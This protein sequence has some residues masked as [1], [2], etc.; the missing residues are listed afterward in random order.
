[1]EHQSPHTLNERV[2]A[3]ISV[4]V[5][6]VAFR[7]FSDWKLRV[8]HSSPP[9]KVASSIVSTVVTHDPNGQSH[10]HDNVEQGNSPYIQLAT[11]IAGDSRVHTN[12]KDRQLQSKNY[13]GLAK[14]ENCWPASSYHFT[15]LLLVGDLN[16]TKVSWMERL[17]AASNGLFAAA[18][19]K[20]LQQGAWTQHVV[21]PTRCRAGQTLSLLDL[22]ITNERHFVHQHRVKINEMFTSERKVQPLRMNGNRRRLRPG[23]EFVRSC[24]PVQAAR[25]LGRWNDKSILKAQETNRCNGQTFATTV[26]C[27]KSASLLLC[28]ATSKGRKIGRKLSFISN[29]R[30]PLNCLRLVHD[31]KSFRALVLHGGSGQ[32]N[33]VLHTGF[34]HKHVS[35]LPKFCRAQRLII[36]HNKIQLCGTY[37]TEPADSSGKDLHK[38][39]AEFIGHKL[40]LFTRR[41][42]I[43]QQSPADH[44]CAQPEASAECVYQFHGYLVEWQVQLVVLLQSAGIR[45]GQTD[46]LQV[47]KFD[48]EVII[49]IIKDSNISVDT[50]ASL[51]YNHKA[52]LISCC[53]T[54][55]TE[56]NINGRDASARSLNTIPT[57]TYTA[58]VASASPEVCSRKRTRRQASEAALRQTEELSD[59][60][61]TCRKQSRQLGF[62]K[63]RNL[64]ETDDHVKP[65]ID[66]ENLRFT[67][68]SGNSESEAFLRDFIVNQRW[69]RKQERRL[70]TYS[71]VLRNAAIDEKDDEDN[72]V[73]DESP[74]SIFNRLNDDNI[75][76]E[77]DDFLVR[78]RDFEREKQTSGATMLSLKTQ[79]SKHRFEEE[80]KEFLKSYPRKITT[81][82]HQS[83]TH[84]GRSARSMKREARR[85]R[86]REQKQAKLAELARLRRLKLALLADKIERIKRT[87]GSGSD[88]LACDLD[89]LKEQAIVGEN[90][91]EV[92]IG[93]TA[94]DL[95]EHLDE[96]W[97]PEKHDRLVERM[98]NDS[99]YQAG[100]DD[101][102]LPRFSD[103]SDLESDHVFEDSTRVEDAQPSQKK[104]KKREQHASTSGLEPMYN[105]HPMEDD[106]CGGELDGEEEITDDAVTGKRVR[107]RLR[108]RAR[109]RRALKR[110]KAPY[111]PAV[112]EDY[113]HYL[114]KHYKLTCEDVIPGP[115]PDEDLFCRFSYRQVTPNDYGL[116]TEEVLTATTGELNSWVPINRVTA[117]RTE[118]E[119]QRDLRVYHSNKKLEKKARVIA[120]LCNPD[121]HWWP[122]DNASTSN[123]P[124]KKRKRSKKKRAGDAAHAQLAETTEKP[125]A[126]GSTFGPNESEYGSDVKRQ[127]VRRSQKLKGVTISQ[128]RLA[129]CNI[130]PK[131]VYRLMKRSKEKNSQNPTAF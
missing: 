126:D 130:T 125:F 46:G 89:K 86:K 35:G 85:A 83:T 68:G 11:L 27:R 100:E 24:S 111:D 88:L 18:L 95:A 56:A 39:L 26:N 84:E 22:D 6:I 28:P 33:K 104:R 59:N 123:K 52:R 105:D 65:S 128:S 7:I 64:P 73:G 77:D 10:K 66:T 13:I 8:P 62:L 55:R 71:E 58:A 1:M 47:M 101:A 120:S 127:K 131:D 103:A 98:F 72:V 38:D 114:D 117:Y 81:S 116:S 76:D 121:A 9:S 19:T 40:L 17:S 102:E 110:P 31:E 109:L 5:F 25:S 96:D 45:S 32:I 119:E 44:Q 49:I 106:N 60:E 51:P 3:Y 82:L 29:M 69:K 92:D 118:E 78:V 42:F 21:A 37:S 30:I 90:E 79:V 122:D 54:D 97:D 108:G 16:A 43:L 14:T 61:D 107:R 99:Y 124:S 129:A 70:P 74:S 12:T 112:D 93:K 23:E 63:R 15:H 113:E 34:C 41:R 80:D 57:P 75:L 94:L 67:D 91:A 53:Q 20:F 115:D 87:C 36:C 48:F 50:D 4:I 2:N